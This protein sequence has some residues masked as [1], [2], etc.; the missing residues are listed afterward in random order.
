MLSGYAASEYFLHERMLG[1][2][3]CHKRVLVVRQR[4]EAVTPPPRY[5]AQGLGPLDPEAVE[6]DW[7]GLWMEA[8]EGAVG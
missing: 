8:P 3:S 7:E 6:A 5:G 4:Q 2:E 1:L